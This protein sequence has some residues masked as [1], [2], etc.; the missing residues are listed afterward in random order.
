VNIFK[1]ERAKQRT[2]SGSDRQPVT[3][4]F[5]SLIANPADEC[6][7]HFPIFF[8]S[9]DDDVQSALPRISPLWMKKK[10]KKNIK[11]E[12]ERGGKWKKS[13]RHEAPP[14]PA[15]ARMNSAACATPA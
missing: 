15:S 5:F 9:D 12:R 4:H 6:K 3:S 11:A 10:K 7:F 13:I 14:H 1:R 2:I 8:L